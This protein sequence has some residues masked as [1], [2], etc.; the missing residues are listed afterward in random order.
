MNVESHKKFQW[1]VVEMGEVTTLIM[2]KKTADL[3]ADALAI[4]SP[5]DDAAIAVA[6]RLETQVRPS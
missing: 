3:V 4:L 2:N 1:S 5:D 6:E